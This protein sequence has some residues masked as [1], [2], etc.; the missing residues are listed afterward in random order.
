MKTVSTLASAAIGREQGRAHGYTD[1]QIMAQLQPIVIDTHALG[2]PLLNYSVY[3]NN[4]ILPGLLQLMIML[5]TVFSIGIEIK[6]KTAREWLGM[7]NN[8]LSFCLLGKLL[9]HTLVFFTVGLGMLSL[10]YAFMQFPVQSGL[11]PMMMALFLFILSAQG[12]GILMTGVLP[13]LR[14][15][16][17]FAGLFGMLSFSIAGFSFPVSAMYPPVQAL[18][19]IFPLRHY[20]LIYVDQALNGRSFF[21]STAHY[22][23]LLLFLLLPFFVLRNL[24][25]ALLYFEY[26]P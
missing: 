4:S 19:N 14:L 12:L 20:Y 17:S 10:L 13:T 1:R 26:K 11:F 21:Y 3:L 25:R 16:L 8:S 7:G 23:A 5:I 2:N 24:K 9:P 18:S 6:E 15:G 22:V